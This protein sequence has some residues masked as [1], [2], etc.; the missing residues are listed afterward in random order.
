ME[1]IDS[2]KRK[3]SPQEIILMAIK[4]RPIEGVSEEQ[5]LSSLLAESKMKGAHMVQVGNTIF[6]GH[7]TEKDPSV[8]LGRAINMDTANNFVNNGQKYFKQLV[9]VGLKTYITMPFNE[10]QF[11]HALKAF[12][13]DKSKNTKTQIL[14][15]E[16]QPGFKMG[17]IT[18]KE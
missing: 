7:F 4:D 16:N 9:D 13:R 6:I 8:V 5:M 10:P 14:D 12:E 18:F 15:V 11:I 17:I 1:M 2:K 3:L